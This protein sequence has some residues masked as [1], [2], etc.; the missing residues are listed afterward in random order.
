MALHSARL[1]GLNVP[2]K[3]FELARKWFDTTGGGK[4]GGL[5]GYQGPGKK[6]PAMVATGMFCRQLDLDPPTSPRQIE[7][8]KLIGINPMRSRTLDF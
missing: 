4:H 5:Y 2:E 1:A 7:S 6:S 3:H 8:A